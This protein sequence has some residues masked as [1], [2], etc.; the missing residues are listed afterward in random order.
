MN[1]LITGITGR[2]GANLAA[3]LISEGHTIHGLVWPRDPSTD[4]LRKL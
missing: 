3:G 2:V 1:I 4:K